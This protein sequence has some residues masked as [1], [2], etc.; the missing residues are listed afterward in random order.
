MTAVSTWNQSGSESMSSP[1][2]SNSTAAIPAPGA[3][4]AAIAVG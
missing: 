4:A 1:S 3:C 2:I